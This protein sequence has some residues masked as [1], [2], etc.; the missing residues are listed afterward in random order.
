MPRCVLLRAVILNIDYEFRI[1]KFI[2]V[3][4]RFQAS[5]LK[6]GLI[7]CSETLAT[8]YQPTPCNIPEE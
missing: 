6:V 3:F 2:S 5:P 7:S 1:K 8:N 4:A